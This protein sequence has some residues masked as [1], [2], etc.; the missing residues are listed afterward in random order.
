MQRK[1][2]D[3]FFQQAFIILVHSN[4]VMER[5]SKAVSNKLAKPGTGFFFFVFAPASIN[6]V[7]GKQAVC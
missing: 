7:N 5:F 4:V 2:A 6:E 3:K 1:S